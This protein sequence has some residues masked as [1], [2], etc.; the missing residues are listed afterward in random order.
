MMY[1]T[2]PACMESILVGA[3][4]KDKEDVQIALN[5][6]AQ[7]VLLASGVTKSDDPYTTLLDLAAGLK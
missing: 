4:V 3:G 5:L 1:P 2:S 6:G 7:G